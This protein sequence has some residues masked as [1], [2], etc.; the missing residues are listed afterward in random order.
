VSVGIVVPGVAGRMGRLLAQGALDDERHALAGATGRPGSAAVGQDAA[1]LVGRAA[2]GVLVADDL[3]ACLAQ[4][5]DAPEQANVVIDFSRAELCA[6]HAR[7]AAAAGAPIVVGTTG[8]DAAA[9]TALDEAASRV[10][11][12]AASNCSLGANLLMALTE[13]ATRALP[14]AD[15]EIVELHHKHKRDAPSGT[16][17]SLADSVA[18]ARGTT[19]EEMQRL[20]RHGDAPRAPGELGV[21]GVRGGDVAGEH[22]VYLFLEGERVELTHR[23]T[24]RAIF[25]RGALAAARWLSGQAPGRYAMRDVLGLELG[26][27]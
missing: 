12:L 7:A 2:T 8:L 21:F 15:A 9:E 23:A 17:L 26:D 25:A 14:D 4:L 13:A 3:A 10:P 16:A 1:A 24:D 11:V 6:S 20:D 22:T 5:A 19:R 18:R 27:G